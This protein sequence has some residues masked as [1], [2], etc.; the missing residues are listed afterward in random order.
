MRSDISSRRGSHLS[1]DQLMEIC[2]M[3]YDNHHLS[4]CRGCRTRYDELARALDHVRDDAVREADTVFT[5]ERLQDQHDR[6]VRRL[7][8]H[9]HPA[10][11][12]MFPSR[13]RTHPTVS[14]VFGPARRWIAGAAAA[15]L[16]A[17]VF[18]GYAVDRRVSSA[19]PVAFVRNPVAVPSVAWQ[20]PTVGRDDQF[21]NELDD[22]MGSRIGELRAIDAMTTPLEIREVSYPR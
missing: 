10:E 16:A 7:E 5:A 17:G 21:L 2:V 13:A 11:V 20:A 3:S 6:I 18:L 12:V 9:G 8:R 19:G 14:R 15:G 1:D 22:L 4:V